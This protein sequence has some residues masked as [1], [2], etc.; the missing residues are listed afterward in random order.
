M[1]LGTIGCGKMGTTLI[2]GAI[3]AGIVAADAVI[4]CDPLPAA[5]EAFTEATGARTTTDPA[6]LANACEVILLCTMPLQAAEALRDAARAAAGQPR[7]VISIAAGITLATLEAACPENFRVIRAMPNTPALVG[8][9][10]AAYCL[11]TRATPADAGTAH[12]LLEA[13]GMALEMPERFMNLVTGLSGSGPAYV[14][15][16]IEALAD[17]GVLAGLT[18][19]VSLRLAAQT[20]LG[21]AAMVL[22][23]NEHPAVLKDKVTSPGGTTIAGLAELERL[24][25]RTALISA[26]NAASLRAAELGKAST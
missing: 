12:T 23:T 18:R 15:V 17:G 6:E 26:V 8:Q 13:V 21:A 20:V 11:G 25:L 3:R 22:E 5:C 14:Y 1:T 9:G 2:A 10:A 7:L 19:A 16:V 24:G 4:G